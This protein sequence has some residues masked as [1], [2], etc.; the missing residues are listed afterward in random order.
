M[1]DRTFA[2]CEFNEQ[3]FNAAL[4][5]LRL[6]RHYTPARLERACEIALATEKRSTRYRD[7]KPGLRSGQDRA[8]TGATA[9]G[10]D[11]AR[12]AGFYG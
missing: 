3:G 1:V 11:Y 8:P 5:V 9:D 7:V 6:S 12:G 4:A 10:C 2:C